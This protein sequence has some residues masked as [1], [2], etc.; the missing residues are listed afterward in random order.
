MKDY[1]ITENFSFYELT[2]TSHTALLER[3]REFAETLKDNLNLLG[4]LLQDIR[5]IIDKPITVSSGVRCPELNKKVGGTADSRH[6]K[7]LA[8]DIQVKG[9]SAMEVFDAIRTTK[10]PLL[11]KAIIEGVKGKEWVHIQAR[12]ATDNAPTQ[13]YATKDGKN[14]SRVG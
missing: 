12:T 7:G 11:Q 8:A 6:Q 9:M 10:L 2:N 13:Y 1:Q 14:Y 3:N 5:D 4:I